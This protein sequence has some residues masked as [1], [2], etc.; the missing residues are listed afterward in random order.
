MPAN[1]LNLS[2]HSPILVYSFLA[3]YGVLTALML[4]YMH[5]KFRTATKALKLIQTEWQTAESRHAGFV[6]AAQE[7]LSKL[8]TTP[9]VPVMPIRHTAVNFDLRN[10]VVAMAKRGIAGPDIA[11][12]CGLNEGEVEVVLGMVRLQR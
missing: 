11:R 10:Q 12:S 6:G 5:A 1:D 3:L 4:T 9:P 2:L 7:Q 8:A